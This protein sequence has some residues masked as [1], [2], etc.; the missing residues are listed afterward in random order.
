MAV[1]AHIIEIGHR[2]LSRSDRQPSGRHL[3]FDLVGAVSHIDKTGP[4]QRNDLW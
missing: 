4:P 2:E 3:T 1:T